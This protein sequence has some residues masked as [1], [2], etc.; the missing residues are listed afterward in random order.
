MSLYVKKSMSSVSKQPL[1]TLD[2]T[3]LAS[4]DIRSDRDDGVFAFPQNEGEATAEVEGGGELNRG[5]NSSYLEL[6]STVSTTSSLTGKLSALFNTMI[7][8]LFFKIYNQIHF[9]VRSQNG[10]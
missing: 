2:A 7:R 9:Q 1:L 8:L 4:R 10:M 5:F 6:C 3:S